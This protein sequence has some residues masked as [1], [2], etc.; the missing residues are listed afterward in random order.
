[1]Q[2]AL[3]GVSI[4]PRAM[5]WVLGAAEKNREPP[6]PDRAVRRNRRPLKKAV[7]AVLSEQIAK[8]YRRKRR[9]IEL[10]TIVTSRHRALAPIS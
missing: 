2:S 6:L 9:D 1:M 3:A 5:P 10:R 8:S 7:R 4:A